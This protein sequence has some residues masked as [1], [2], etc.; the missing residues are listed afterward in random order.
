M[1]EQK[2]FDDVLQKPEP[3]SEFSSHG[4]GDSHWL[5]AAEKTKTSVLGFAVALTFTF[6]IIELVGFLWGNSLALIGDAGHMVTDSASL[7][8]ALV[9]NKIAQ[10]G[11]DDDH[12]FGH[13]RVEV[14]AAFI[15]GLVMLCVVGWIFF[16]AVSRI[17]TPEPVSGLSVMAIA[18]VGLVIN[19]L[20]A[21]SLSRARKNMNTRAALLHVMGDLLGSVAAIVA[22]AVIYFG[23]PTIADP[24]LS[25]VVCCLLLHATWEILRDSTRVLLDSVPEGVNYFSV[26]RTIEAIPGVNRVHDLHVWTM[27]PGHGAIQCHVHIESPECWPKILDVLRRQLHEEFQIDHVTV[28]P[29]GLAAKVEVWRCRYASSGRLP[30]G[31]RRSEGR[32]CGARARC[33]EALSGPGFLSCRPGE[34]PPGSPGKKSCRRR[35]NSRTMNNRPDSEA[36]RKRRRFSGVCRTSV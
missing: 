27:S 1:S 21:W 30:R 17:M 35:E 36:A 14:L 29:V 13:G 23:G 8:F 22:G 10:K 31:L 19:I 18:A 9:A 3:N 2:H 12:S 6:S 16:E 11:A 4:R 15:N 20:V 7:L 33:G 25:L 32:A 26:G 34:E 5:H 24:I 28:W